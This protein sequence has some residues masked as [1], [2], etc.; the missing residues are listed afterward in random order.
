[1]THII[2]RQNNNIFYFFTFDKNNDFL[3]KGCNVLNNIKK[4][5]FFISFFYFGYLLFLYKPDISVWGYLPYFASAISV[6]YLASYVIKAI[7]HIGRNNIFSTETL[8]LSY[9]GLS[10][11]YI[12]FGIDILQS[13]EFVGEQYFNATLNNE[14]YKNMTDSSKTD[15]EFLYKNLISFLICLVM[16]VILFNCSRAFYMIHLLDRGT[17]RNNTISDNTIKGWD[18]ILRLLI[19]ITFIVFEKKIS[20]LDYF[21]TNYKHTNTEQAALQFSNS[22][23]YFGIIGGFL[24]SLLLIWSLYNFI[25]KVHNLETI[26]AQ[27]FIPIGGLI[28]SFMLFKAADTNYVANKILGN[29]TLSHIITVT[30]IIVLFVIISTVLIITPPLIDK[31]YLLLKKISNTTNNA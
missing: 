3:L 15:F 1:M 19:A 11:L 5:S 21:L 10:T 30:A 22:L 13:S 29:G 6:F 31:F 2:V 16:G 27:I 9:V 25:K 14:S 24:Y 28:Y 4:I 26:F 12:F 20:E 8:A 7:G 18:W 23:S 17:L